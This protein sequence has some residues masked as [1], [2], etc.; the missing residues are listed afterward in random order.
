MA[1]GVIIGT[2]AGPSLNASSS[3]IDLSLLDSMDEDI[4]VRII[5]VAK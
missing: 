4:E 5:C 2:I 3:L 1:S